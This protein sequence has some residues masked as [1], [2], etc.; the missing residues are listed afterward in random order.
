MSPPLAEAL[1]RA[2]SCST[3]RSKAKGEPFV[4]GGRFSSGSGGFRRRRPGRGR[5]RCAGAQCPPPPPRRTAL[6]ALPTAGSG[7]EK[8]LPTG[9]ARG[10]GACPP[11]PIEAVSRAPRSAPVFLPS[12]SQDAPKRRGGAQREPRGSRPSPE[13]SLLQRGAVRPPE[14]SYLQNSQTVF[15]LPNSNLSLRG[16]KKTGPSLKPQFLTVDRNKRSGFP[17]LHRKPGTG[18]SKE[19]ALEQQGWW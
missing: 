11:L 18:R 5:G 13:R 7:K 1:S 8:S 2:R 15:E 4:A 12:V 3:K 9:E 17:L 19:K 14:W 10:E 16:G 6:P